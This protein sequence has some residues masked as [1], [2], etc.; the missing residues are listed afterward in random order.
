MTTNRIAAL[1]QERNIKVATFARTIGVPQHTLYSLLKK[2]SMDNITI[3]VFLKI[4]KGLGMTAE[5][6]YNGKPE[7]VH[8]SDARQQSL[9]RNYNALNNRGKAK[10]SEYVSDLADMDKYT[11]LEVVKGDDIIAA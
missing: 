10:A 3:S 7:E 11:A 9:N 8:Y 1:L 4:A 6:L 2:P 5:E